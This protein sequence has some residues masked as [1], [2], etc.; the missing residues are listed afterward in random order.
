MDQ[1]KISGTLVGVDGNAFALMGAFQRDARR[2]GWLKAEI[3]K[4][5]ETAM[6]GN[7]DQLVA[8]LAECYEN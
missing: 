1:P 2:A 4:I 6:S 8:T 7:Y 3:D 5:L